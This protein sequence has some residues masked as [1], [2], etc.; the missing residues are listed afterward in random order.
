MGMKDENSSAVTIGRAESVLLLDLVFRWEK[1]KSRSE[2]CVILKQHFVL[3]KLEPF[4]VGFQCVAF[5]F[6]PSPLCLGTGLVLLTFP[7]R[8]LPTQLAS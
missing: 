1:L 4:S 5:L 6:S 7:T 8:G 3:Y 2:F